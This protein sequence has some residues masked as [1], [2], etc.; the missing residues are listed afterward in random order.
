MN[1]DYI[2]SLLQ[3]VQSGTVDAKQALE[4]LA[5]FPFVDTEHARIDTQR[6]LRQGNPEV[7][8]GLG[9]SVAQIVEIARGLA[10]GGESVLVTRVEPEVAVAVRAEIAEI[11]AAIG[12]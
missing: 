1:R 5:R 7:V 8:F 12:L 10:A 9:K 3:D 11:D 6:G 2:L 4:Q